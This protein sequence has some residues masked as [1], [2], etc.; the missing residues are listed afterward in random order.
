MG[1]SVSSPW[2]MTAHSRPIPRSIPQ[3]A[4]GSLGVADGWQTIA[5]SLPGPSSPCGWVARWPSWGYR[6][7]SPSRPAAGRCGAGL[8][9]CGWRCLSSSTAGRS[10]T[11]TCRLPG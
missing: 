5:P 1:W 4:S 8:A 6:C 3:R 7:P 10:A 11:G 9:G 2:A